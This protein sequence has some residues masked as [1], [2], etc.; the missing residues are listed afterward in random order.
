MVE[1]YPAQVVAEAS[2]G[3]E[4]VRVAEQQRPD[5][6]LLD[7]SM[8]VRNG[9]WAAQQLHTLLPNLWIIMVSEHSEKVYVEEVFH[10]GAHGYVWKQ[11]AS[12]ELVTA[13][14]TVLAGDLYRSS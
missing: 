8:P 14:D 7:V 2:D 13:M 11:R 12:A 6:A 4:A 10:S 5:L 1:S 9:L 3:K